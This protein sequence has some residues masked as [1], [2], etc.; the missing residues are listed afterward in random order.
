MARIL[1]DPQVYRLAIEAADHQCQ[2]ERTRGRGAA[3]TTEQCIHSDRAGY[4]LVLVVDDTRGALVLCKD[5]LAKLQAPIARRAERA[6]LAGQESL[7]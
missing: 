6:V 4:V 1:N 5:C 2:G 7:F 3:K